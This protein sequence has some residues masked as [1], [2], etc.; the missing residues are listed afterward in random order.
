MRALLPTVSALLLSIGILVTGNGL[1]WTLIPVRASILAFDPIEIGLLGSSY[2]LGFAL[3]CILGGRVIQRVGH[4]RTFTALTAIASTV[5]MLHALTSNPMAWWALRSITG[6]C[7]AGLYLV[8]ESWLNERATNDNRGLVMG[9]YTMI[10]LSVTIVGQMMLTLGDPADFPLFALASILISL[11]AVPVAL[12]AARPPA[13]LMESRLRPVKLYTGSPVGVVGVLLAGVAT[14]AF[15]SLGPAYAIAF[16]ANTSEI[17]IFMSITVLGGALVQWPI[18][19]LSDAFDRRIVVI[20]LC[21]IG[22][23]A[24]LILALANI[25]ERVV[26]AILVAA[27]GAS[28]MPLYAICA[29]HAFD[30]IETQDTVETSSGLLLA[31]GIGA[32]AGPIAAAFF[33]GPLGPGGLFIA[34]AG[35]HL[36]LAA[37]V[38]WRIRTSHP[39]PREERSEFDLSTT[40]P[41]MVALMPL[42]KESD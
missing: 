28:A 9:I 16:G 21:G 26:T 10:N 13:R 38:I 30:H 23:F 12:T 25:E 31:N 42:E 35:A 1:Q 20:G 14:G 7:F 29:A 6:F 33:M 5:A 41:T 22:V 39:V 37:F 15:W 24:A 36:M 2:Y 27:F 17:A 8:I 18:G 32:I 40:A 19:R 34:T 3:G 11:A 4:I